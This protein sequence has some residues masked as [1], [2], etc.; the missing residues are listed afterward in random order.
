MTNKMVSAEINSMKDKLL[1]I[2][3]VI[4]PSIDG[5]NHYF[6]SDVIAKHFG[7]AIVLVESKY[8]SG[9]STSLKL[10]Y[11]T[12]L[13]PYYKSLFDKYEA[14]FKTNIALFSRMKVN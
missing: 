11:L 2:K 5:Q 3:I 4:D 1:F 6:I 10:D 12:G 8:K 7:G 14:V 13:T 9:L